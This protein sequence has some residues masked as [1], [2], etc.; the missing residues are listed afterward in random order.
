M[1]ETLP[2]PERKIV[3]E[4]LSH[5]SP[6]AESSKQEQINDEF[7]QMVSIDSMNHLLENQ[8]E[9]IWDDIYK[10]LKAKINT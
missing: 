2:P 8:E 6:S 9:D 3:Y 1:I 5:R 4:W 10:Q 7:L